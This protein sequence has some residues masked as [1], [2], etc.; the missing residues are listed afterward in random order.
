MQQ[1]Q[2][3]FKN[4]LDYVFS[5]SDSNLRR[6]KFDR[7]ISDWF[8]ADFYPSY[9]NLPYTLIFEFVEWNVHCNFIQRKLEKVARL[10]SCNALI[11]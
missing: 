9:K 6:I 7:T 2:N 4:D 5:T 8:E 3:Y 1:N 10:S 11:L